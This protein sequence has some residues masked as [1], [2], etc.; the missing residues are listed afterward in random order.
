MSSWFARRTGLVTGDPS[1]QLDAYKDGRRDERLQ[2]QAGAPD[3]RLARAE[4]SDAH[5]R[6]RREGRLSS[7]ASPLGVLS[8][9]LV[10]ALAALAVCAIVLAVNYGSFTG[11]GQ[12][13]DHALAS[14][15]QAVSPR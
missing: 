3:R 9:L 4:L 7:R 10:L 5:S 6:G 13:A 12:A 15:V 11:A 2:G 14:L 8:G 1:T